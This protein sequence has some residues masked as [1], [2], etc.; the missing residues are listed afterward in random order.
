V[1]WALV[2]AFSL[3]ASWLQEETDSECKSKIT[4]LVEEEIG[5]KSEMKE[6]GEFLP[7]FTNSEDDESVPAFERGGSKHRLLRHQCL[8][9]RSAMISWRNMT[10]QV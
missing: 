8:F 7:A 2:R 3:H 6:I 5:A 1:R 9:T 4:R 10:A